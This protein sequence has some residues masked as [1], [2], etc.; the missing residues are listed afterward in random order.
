MQVLILSV[1][2]LGNSNFCGSLGSVSQM[3]H[4]KITC[5]LPFREVEQ[6]LQKK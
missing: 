2:V 3:H 1:E 6:G 4:A 5:V